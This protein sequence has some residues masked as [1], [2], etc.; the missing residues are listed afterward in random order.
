LSDSERLGTEPDL[1]SKFSAPMNAATSP[2]GVLCDIPLTF[3]VVAA[4]GTATAGVYQLAPN[5]PVWGAGVVVGL[6]I[7]VNL[8]AHFALR[9]ARVGVVDWLRTVPFPL[10]N[11]NAVLSGSG[12]YFDIFM[13]DE[14]PEREVIMSFLERSSSD[15]F[16]L[17]QDEERRV[18]SAR[19]GVM[20]SKLNPYREAFL[21]YERMRQVVELALVPMHAV[22]PIERVLIT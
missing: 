2:M 22:H 17:E 21:R 4:L 7:V 9:G 11:V 20:V 3:G 1:A 18:V 15:V 19:F 16:V 8:A 13:R 10:E 14:L 12:E 5:L 6:P